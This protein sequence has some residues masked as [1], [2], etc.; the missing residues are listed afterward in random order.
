MAGIS[1]VFGGS[2]A[3]GVKADVATVF[4]RVA[5]ACRRGFAD[6]GLPARLRTDLARIVPYDFACWGL[7]DPTTLWPVTNSSTLT[8][9]TAALRAWDQELLAADVLKINQL[10]RTRSGAGALGLATNGEPTRSPRYRSVLEP[11]G[12]RD[13]LRVVLSVDNVHWGWLALFR[14]TPDSFT[15]GEVATMSGLAPH[16]ARAWRGAL[17]SAVTGI[18]TAEQPPAVV[19]LGADDHVVSVTPAGGELLDALPLGRGAPLADVLH[20]LALATRVGGRDLHVGNRAANT[21]TGPGST[22]ITVPRSDGSWVVLE[23]ARLIGSD[24]QVVVTLRPAGRTELSVVLLRSH[25][26]TPRETEI[27]LAALGTHTTV[28]IAEALF[29]SP[30]TVQDHLK[31]IFAK[32]GARSRR[33]LAMQ[34]LQAP[35]VA[36]GSA[37][38]AAAALGLH[39]PAR[40]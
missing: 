14:R 26:L 27:A 25:G 38:E 33:E 16:L 8:D 9:S 18:D 31:A 5:A 32:T 13:E 2:Y 36:T 11:I 17:L 39:L 7:L 37:S 3:E 10:A 4:E 12:V 28:E 6:P 35:R 29:V 40:D 34:M 23:A 20:V 15:H 19:V 22:R 24:D 21:I 1:R 30:Y